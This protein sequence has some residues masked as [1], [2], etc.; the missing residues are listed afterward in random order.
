M[1]NLSLKFS[2]TYD[3]I[4]EMYGSI[5]RDVQMSLVKVNAGQ[6]DDDDDSVS[7]TDS[8]VFIY[9]L[10]RRMLEQVVSRFRYTKSSIL[11]K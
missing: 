4:K 3:K 2:V 11:H 5:L 8:S 9:S 1:T 6:P 7:L 10:G